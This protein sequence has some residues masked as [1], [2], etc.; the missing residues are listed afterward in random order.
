MNIL[1]D[2]KGNIWLA[3]WDG[4]NKF[5]GY[6]FKTYKASQE[7]QISLT[8]N[9]V[10][11]IREDDDG[12]IWMLSYD[13]RAHRF[14]PGTETFEAVPA[15]GA[16][17]DVN[18]TEIKVIP[19][20]SVWLITENEGVIR[21]MTD[22]VTHDV[23]TQV[24]SLQSGLFPCL[25]VHDVCRDS[26]GNEWLLT[27]NGLAMVK[28]GVLAPVGYFVETKETGPDQK[29]MFYAFCESKGIKFEE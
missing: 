29:Q 22:S 18:I 5:D 14:D 6:D 11:M 23:A 4:I 16:G 1:Q 3:T 2:H 25:K 10:D 27:D 13:N 26:D 24:Y 8:S 21:A 12:Y 7:N 9:R 17:S 28:P 19:G 15:F 20:G